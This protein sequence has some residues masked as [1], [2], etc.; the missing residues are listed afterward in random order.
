MLLQQTKESAAGTI[1]RPWQIALCLHY[2]GNNSFVFFNTVKTY[3]FKA[4]DSQIKPDPLCVGYVSNSF[5][6]RK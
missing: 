6:I 2:K 5:T 1:C 4:K 3:Q